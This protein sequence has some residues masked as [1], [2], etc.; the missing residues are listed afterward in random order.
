MDSYLLEGLPSAS[1][2]SH[3]LNVMPHSLIRLVS[4]GVLS[5]LKR[6]ADATI[7]RIRLRVNTSEIRRRRCSSSGTIRSGSILRSGGAVKPSL[8]LADLCCGSFPF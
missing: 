1:L 8:S 3:T 4:I 6:L 7:S 2:T 5:C